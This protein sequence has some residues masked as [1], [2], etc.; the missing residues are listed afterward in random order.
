M[1]TIGVETVTSKLSEVIVARIYPENDLL[2]G[3]EDICRQHQITSGTVVSGFGTLSHTS[4]VYV[5]A[6]KKTLDGTSFVSPIR[7]E[8]PMD[9]LSLQGSIGLTDQG[10]ISIHLHG[11]VSDPHQ[12]VYGG[13]LIPSKNPVLTT[14]EI[15]ICADP[16]RYVTQTMDQETHFGMFHQEPISSPTPH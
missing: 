12:R 5:V 10:N 6:D 8:G 13:H 4:F 9:L 16:G 7:M 15:M 14:V 3:V 11:M 1:N 2:Q